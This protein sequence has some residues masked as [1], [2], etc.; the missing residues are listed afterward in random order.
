MLHLKFKKQKEKEKYLS[1]V[2]IAFI[3]LTDLALGPSLRIKAIR[4]STI[5]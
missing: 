1:A 2:I 3:Y 5:S 4:E